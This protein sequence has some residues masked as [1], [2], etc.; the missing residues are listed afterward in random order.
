[1]ENEEQ[2][3][4]VQCCNCNT[5]IYEHCLSKEPFEKHM[6]CPNCKTCFTAVID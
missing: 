4:A 2:I 6:E 1:M 3:Y 5:W